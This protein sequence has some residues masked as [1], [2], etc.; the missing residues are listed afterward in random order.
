LIG[1]TIGISKACFINNNQIAYSASQS[2]NE[3]SLSFVRRMEN[4]S[5]RIEEA[6]PTESMTNFAVLDWNIAKGGDLAR[7]VNA[8]PGSEKRRNRAGGRH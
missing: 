4:Q 6:R 2:D 5:C 1:L 7:S 3:K 8:G